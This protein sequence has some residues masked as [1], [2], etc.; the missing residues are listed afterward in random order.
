MKHEGKK[1]FIGYLKPAEKSLRPIVVHLNI[2]GKD[3]EGNKQACGDDY[4][5]K[6]FLG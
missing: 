1:K 4:A 6:S 5:E 3:K 2:A